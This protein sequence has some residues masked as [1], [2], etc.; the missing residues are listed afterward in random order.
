MEEVEPLLRDPH[1]YYPG[2]RRCA[3]CKWGQLQQHITATIPGDDFWQKFWNDLRGKRVP[4]FLYNVK[5]RRFPKREYM[6]CDD[7]CGE[8]LDNGTGIGIK[9]AP[10]VSGH[11]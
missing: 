3:Q 7:V 11:G 10:E 6:G 5:C 1:E 8:F 4:V 2:L 9:L